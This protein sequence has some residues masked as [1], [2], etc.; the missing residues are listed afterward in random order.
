MAADSMRHH[1]LAARRASAGIDGA[2]RIMRTAHIFF[3][4]RTSAFGCLHD[5]LLPNVKVEL[6][7]S[8]A[9]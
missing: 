4:M 5:G 1:G 2:E 3:R 9:V 8:A 7:R 6:I